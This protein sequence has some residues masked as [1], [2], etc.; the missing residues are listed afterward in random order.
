MNKTLP[1]F[2]SVILLCISVLSY[3]K[4]EGVVQYHLKVTDA[5]HHLAD[6]TVRFPEVAPGRFVVKLPAWRT[7]KYKILDL[8]NGISFLQAFD[9]TM[10]GL[11]VTK[12]DKASWQIEVKERGPLTIG[13]QLYANQLNDRARHIDDTHIF[14]DA[15]AGFIFN[16]TY[17]MSPVRV[18]L[19]VPSQWQSRSGMDKVAEHTFIANDYDQLVD[20]PIE[21]GIHKYRA[22]TVEDRE[23]ELVVWGEGNYDLD[24]IIEDLTKLD[25]AAKDF[26]QAFPFKRYVYMV[27]VAPGLRGATEH[28]NSTIIHSTPYRF[29][30][31]KDYIG[32]AQI[33][34]HEFVHTWNVKHYRP[35]GIARYDYTK[36]NYS[37]SLWIAEGS[38]SYIQHLL[39]VRSGTISSNEFMD[40]LAKNIHSYRH[41]PGR[42][43]MSVARAS[44][45]A[46]IGHPDDDNLNHNVSIYQEGLLVTLVL[47][48]EIRR[49]TNNQKSLEDLH[50]ALYAKVTKEHKGFNESQLLELLQHI[51]GSSFENFWAHY[52]HGTQE[53]PLE[54]ALAFYGLTMENKHAKAEAWSGLT[55]AEHKGFALVTSV[56]RGSPAWQ[57]GLA[58]G[59]LIISQQKQQAGGDLLQR[60]EDYQPG[61]K[62]ELYYFRKNSLR[63]ST[64]LLTQNPFPEQKIV[65]KSDN[66]STISARFKSWTQQDISSVKSD[67]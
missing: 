18:S 43:R 32:F 65:P 13:Y 35:D 24:A 38:T 1:F 11:P 46:W 50:R 64:L 10:N 33:A 63:K 6:I 26:W 40:S 47:D 41:K 23:Y 55:I 48:Y 8:A 28:L 31:R 3:A 20:S 37:P 45:D 12:V 61:E 59:D 14:L 54:N 17:R 21:S 58:T 39:G 4:D 27:H 44:F 19:E 53:L 36:E 42:N 25:K 9:A 22:F 7:G 51:T 62:L 34:A 2:T 49:L 66:N 52:V 60:F 29:K 67:S 30:K 56:E 5:N 16:D 57:A 15:S